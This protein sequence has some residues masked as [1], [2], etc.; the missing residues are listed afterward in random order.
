[1][2]LL[3]EVTIILIDVAIITLLIIMEEIIITVRTVIEMIIDIHDKVLRM[4]I[5]HLSS[6][7]LIIA[8]LGCVMIILIVMDTALILIRKRM[9]VHN[10]HVS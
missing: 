3:I 4:T 10:V 5:Y 7:I 6:A 1:M 2:P 8:Q 9:M